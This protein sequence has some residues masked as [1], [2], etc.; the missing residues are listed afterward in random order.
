M[1]KFKCNLSIRNILVAILIIIVVL[2]TINGISTLM[3]KTVEAL[4]KNAVER[5]AVH[6]V[7][8]Y[9]TDTSKAKPE[10]ICP[11]DTPICNQHVEGKF[12]GVCG[13][14][15]APNKMIDFVFAEPRPAAPPKSCSWEVK[16]KGF[17][18]PG[19]DMNLT[20]L[21]PAP[22]PPAPAPAP[23]SGKC[24]PNVPALAVVGNPTLNVIA[25]NG[26]KNYTT[27]AACGPIGTMCPACCVWQ[28][29]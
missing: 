28:G 9:G 10:H 25:G 17:D 12:M 29:S 22:P 7:A 8:D 20:P 2:V 18:Y 6:C 24:I 1:T 16:E 3:G 14:K 13:Y 21:P 19:N 27:K 26:C 5:A 4:D 11:K 23:L 15:K